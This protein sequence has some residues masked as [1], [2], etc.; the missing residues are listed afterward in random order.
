MG[1]AAAPQRA[2]ARDQRRPEAAE[3]N[4]W[5][6]GQ[7]RRLHQPR[8]PGGRHFAGAEHPK[9]EAEVALFGGVAGEQFDPC[10]FAQTRNALPPRDAAVRMRAQKRTYAFNQ[11]GHTTA[12]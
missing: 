12:R 2:A 4:H 7:L 6:V 1:R 10:Y 8:D 3:R 11:L 5:E 9:T